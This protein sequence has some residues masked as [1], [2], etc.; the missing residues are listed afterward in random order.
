MDMAWDRDHGWRR[1]LGG[2]RSL[3]VGGYLDRGMGWSLGG[4]GAL[5]EKLAEVQEP[6]SGRGQLDRG[7]GWDRILGG[8]KTLGVAGALKWNASGRVE[9]ACI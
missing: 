8:C 7:L 6:E 5:V 9:S 2:C 3:G 1:R 4:T